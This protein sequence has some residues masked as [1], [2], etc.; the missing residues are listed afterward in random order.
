M[1]LLKLAGRVTARVLAEDLG[2]AGV[3]VVVSC[4]VVHD[5]VDGA[6][7]ANLGEDM[8]PELSHCKGSLY[9]RSGYRRLSEKAALKRAELS[10]KTLHVETLQFLPLGLIFRCKSNERSFLC[11]RTEGEVCQG[12]LERVEPEK[13]GR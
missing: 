11:L 10:E 1:G 13:Q 5:S 2:A 3:R 6:V 4:K 7:Q 8:S 12:G 9:E